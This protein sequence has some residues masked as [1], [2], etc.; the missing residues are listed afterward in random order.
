MKKTLQSKQNIKAIRCLFF[1]E[2]LILVYFDTDLQ[3][4]CLFLTISCL[5]IVRPT[6][7]KVAVFFLFFFFFYTVITP[8]KIQFCL[9]SGITWQGFSFIFQF[10]NSP[11]FIFYFLQP[12][13][14]HAYLHLEI[15]YFILQGFVVCV[16]Y[17]VTCLAIRNYSQLLQCLLQNCTFCKRPIIL[18]YTQESISSTAQCF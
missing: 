6:S 1:S 7:T 5:F 12:W 11:N 16:A 4:I 17:S 2:Y 14:L 10:S 8:I 13:K 15:V 9:C 18:H 3:I